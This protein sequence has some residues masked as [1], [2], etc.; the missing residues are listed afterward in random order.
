[1]IITLIENQ[2]PEGVYY[3]TEKFSLY[4]YDDSYYMQIKLTNADLII[5]TNTGRQK[6]VTDVGYARRHINEWG[7]SWYADATSGEVSNVNKHGEH[8][9]KWK[10]ENV[11]YDEF[12]FQREDAYGTQFIHALRCQSPLINTKVHTREGHQA[13]GLELGRDNLIMYGPGIQVLPLAPFVPK[14]TLQ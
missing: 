8:N 10:V 13:L 6:F 7:I 3:N 1:M 4:I 2:E 5:Q 12:T 14:N 11:I 9:L